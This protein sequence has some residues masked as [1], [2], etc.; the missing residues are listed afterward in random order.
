MKYFIVSDIHGNLEAMQSVLKEMKK[1]KPDVKVCLGDIVGYGP[2]PDECT[3]LAFSVFDV[4]VAGNHDQAVTGQYS[5]DTFNPLARMAVEWS[6]T[7]ITEKN[8][9]RLKSLNLITIKNNLTFVHAT[10]SAP[11]QFEYILST[12]KAK[13]DFP[14]LTTPLCFIGHTHIP[15]IYTQHKKGNVKQVMEKS[16]H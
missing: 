7:Q 8:I 1:E 13:N 4:I 11:G 2:D 10:P 16:L 15:I 5:T 14:D 6:Q 12:Y 3:E 9:A